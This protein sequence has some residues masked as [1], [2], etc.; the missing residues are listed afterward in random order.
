M[1][2]R[3]ASKSLGSSPSALQV[4]WSACSAYCLK[5]EH[6][7]NLP[8]RMSI[9]TRGRTGFDSRK[10]VCKCRAACRFRRRRRSACCS[11]A[12]SPS[13][14]CRSPR[15]DRNTCASSL[16]AHHG[17]S[18]VSRAYILLAAVD[19]RAASYGQFVGRGAE[20]ESLPVLGRARRT[21]GAAVAH[22]THRDARHA[23]AEAVELLVATFCKPVLVYSILM[24]GYSNQGRTC[25]FIPAQRH[26]LVAPIVALLDTVAHEGERHARTAALLAHQARVRALEHV[27][28]YSTPTVTQWAHHC[29]R[30]GRARRS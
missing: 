16:P 12:C 27:R 17:H 2:C 18:T 21:V 19:R 20:R 7:Y 23:V 29:T 10:S 26:G 30:S 14:T 11:P 28:G 15:C 13:C 6:V 24:E 22:L 8:A 9:V 4:R 5:H 25:V 1:F 3:L